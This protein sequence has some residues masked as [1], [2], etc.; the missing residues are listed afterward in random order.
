MMIGAKLPEIV[1]TGR[2]MRDIS[3]DALNALEAAN[4]NRGIFVRAGKLC[5]L[6]EMVD[7][8]PFVEILSDNALKGRLERVADFR[9]QTNAGL[10]PTPPPS[11]V[12]KDILALEKWRFPKIDGIVEV[13]VLRAN[14]TVLNNAGYDPDT[15]LYYWPQPEFGIPR[16]PKVPTEDRVKAAVDLLEETIGDFPFEDQ[17]SKANTLALMLTPIVRP[18]IRGTVPLALIDAPQQGTGKSLLAKVIAM[19]P[20]GRPAA[21]MA[22]PDNDEE[23]RKR[24]TATLLSGATVITI[25]NLEGALSSASLANAL[26]AEVWQD[27]ILGRNETVE[28]SQRCTWMATGNNIR[29]GGDI[30]R[31]CYKIRLDAKSWT[32]WLGREFRHPNLL[33]WVTENRGRLVAALLVLARSWVA[34]GRP[35]GAG[36]LLGSFEEWCMVVGGILKYAGIE[37]FLGN[38]SSLYETADEESQE[39]A[40]FLADLQAKYRQPFTTAEVARDL[41]NNLNLASTLPSELWD[42]YAKRNRDGVSFTRTLGKAFAKRA[43]RRH[44]PNEYHLETAGNRQNAKLWMVLTKDLDAQEGRGEANAAD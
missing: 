3:H 14:G 42:D 23:W 43:G 27:R 25:D 30:Q 22:A 17:S 39:W 33:Q 4:E 9:K 12:V 11:N 6:R 13:P 31:R 26:T 44:G 36:P 5:R 21:M 41:P 37:G 15:R 32:P 19:I 2:H 29:L 20:T 7:D 1:T 16:I 8:R 40:E 24:I 34:A 10:R 28:I 18:A 35:S 38:L